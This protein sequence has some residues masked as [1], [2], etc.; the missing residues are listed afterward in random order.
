[1]ESGSVPARI[2]ALVSDWTRIKKQLRVSKNLLAENPRKDPPSKKSVSFLVL[3]F[4]LVSVCS[5]FLFFPLFVYPMF[6]A[7]CCPPT[8]PLCGPKSSSSQNIYESERSYFASASEWKPNHAVVFAD[9][10]IKVHL[11][12]LRETIDWL[13]VG[14]LMALK[15]HVFVQRWIS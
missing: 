11:G 2:P 8:S 7:R 14:W 10:S 4:L 13:P 12:V 9:S 6:H 5:S 3:M 15:E 1:M